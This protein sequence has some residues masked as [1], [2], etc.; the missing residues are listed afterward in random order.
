MQHE[1]VTLRTCDLI[2]A[3]LDWAVAKAQGVEIELPCSD[4]VWAKYAGVYSPSTDWSQGGPLIDKMLK[5]GKWEIIQWGNPGVALQNFDND[6][7]P[8]DG[9][10]YGDKS[11]LQS[12]ETV[13]IAACRAI[14]SAHLG[15]SVDVPAELVGGG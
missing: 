4:V 14:V 1:T 15:D 2:G 10:S 6:C 9:V 8:V 3:A 13:L 11:I 5:S 12:G 7:L